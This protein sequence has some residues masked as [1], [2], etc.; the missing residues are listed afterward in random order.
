MRANRFLITIA[1][2][3]PLGFLPAPG[4]VATIATLPLVFAFSAAPLAHVCLVLVVLSLSVPAIICAQ[5]YLHSHDPSQIVIDEVLGCL[6]AFL[7]VPFSW[8][9]F[10]LGFMLFRFFDIFKPWPIGKLEHVHGPWGV[11]LDDVVAGVMSNIILQLLIMYV[12]P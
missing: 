9:A 3:G 1:T 6:V 5:T 7:A 12:M 8:W 11:L 2:L 4:T 10:I